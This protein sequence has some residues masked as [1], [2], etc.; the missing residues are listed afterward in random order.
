MMLKSI[1]YTYR[2]LPLRQ[3]IVCFSAI[4]YTDKERCSHH[5]NK[6][7]EGNVVSGFAMTH[8]YDHKRTDQQNA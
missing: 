1:K 5:D 3:F 8:G 6:R 2:F 4:V 7:H